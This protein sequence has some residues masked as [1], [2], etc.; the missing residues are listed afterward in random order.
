MSATCSPTE[1]TPLASGPYPHVKSGFGLGPPVFVIRGA[2]DKTTLYELRFEGQQP[3]IDDISLDQPILVQVTQRPAREVV[4]LGALWPM[5]Q[6]GE[7][8]P[9]F[10]NSSPHIVRSAS[11]PKAA[12]SLP[13]PTWISGP[14]R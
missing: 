9:P 8:G 3:R 12:P 13:I 14:E 4:P 11:P 2:A 5:P 1:H 6:H 7:M 10:P